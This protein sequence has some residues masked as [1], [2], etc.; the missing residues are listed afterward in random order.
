[1]LE[2]RK[3]DPSEV[4][5][6]QELFQL[7]FGDPPA[8]SGLYFD[9]H[10]RPEE[11]LV[12]REDGVLCAMGGLLGVTLSAPDGRA[13]KAAYLYAL[14]THPQYR[15]RGHARA[16]LQYADFY[17]RGKRDCLITVPSESALFPFYEAAGFR[18]FFPLLEGEVV[19]R[20]PQ[21]GG[22]CQIDAAAYDALRES[23]LAKTYHVSYGSLTGLQEGLCGYCQG[24]LLALEADGQRGCAAVERWGETVMIKELL[25]PPTAL[26]EALAQTAAQVPGS[27]YIL[28]RPAAQ[29]AL[30]LERR[31]F[32]MIKWFDPI[33]AKRWRQA[34]A[35]YLGLAFD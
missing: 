32:G 16:L 21:C 13:V 27:R 1:M 28:R 11:F 31:M 20:A 8:C 9:H 24:A 5:A 35:P 15:G 4:P 29:P 34:E 23:L 2:L 25:C 12:L 18:A 6:L 14:G 7:C 30:G 17:L 22:A 10:Y 33:A 26:E 3:S 19:P